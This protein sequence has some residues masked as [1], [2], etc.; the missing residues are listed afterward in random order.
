MKLLN[1][2]ADVE[3]AENINHA[4]LRKILNY[5]LNK[6]V[7]ALAEVNYGKGVITLTLEVLEGKSEID[8][9]FQAV[10]LKLIQEIFMIK[11]FPIKWIKIN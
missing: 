1:N 5:E 9:L 2:H 4:V 7:T 8:T 3:K 6:Y 10:R 11:I